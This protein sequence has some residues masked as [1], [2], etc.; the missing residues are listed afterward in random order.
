MYLENTEHD[1]DFLLLKSSIVPYQT[2]DLSRPIPND[3]IDSRFNQTLLKAKI[4]KPKQVFFLNNVRAIHSVNVS[5]Q[6]A[7]RIAVI[8][9][10]G[11][12]FAQMPVHLKNL[13]VH[14]AEKFKDLAIFR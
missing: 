10:I 5:T 7:F 8:V 6:G 11:K 3:G 14:S 2:K 12:N 13:I 1:K 9:T 4:H